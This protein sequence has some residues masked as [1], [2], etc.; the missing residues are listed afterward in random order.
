[1]WGVTK[2]GTSPAT[3]GR[4]RGERWFL[5]TMVVSVTRSKTDTKNRCQGTDF[6]GQRTGTGSV[7]SLTSHI[8]SGLWSVWLCMVFTICTVYLFIKL[9]GFAVWLE[10]IQLSSELKMFTF[11]LSVSGRWVTNTKIKKNHIIPS[12]DLLKHFKS[13]PSWGFTATGYDIEPWAE[14]PFSPLSSLCQ[15]FYHG[16]ET[17]CW[18]SQAA[19][20]HFCC[21]PHCLDPLAPVLLSV[22]FGGF[23]GRDWAL[24]SAELN[25]LCHRPQ[26]ES[27][28]S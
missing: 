1:M 8:V 20:W 7:R 13:V 22:P 23:C 24:C 27:V 26:L 5:E 17:W 21:S 28:V 4:G 2:P 11:V 19:Q 16:K 14:T 3:T 12:W 10:R 25:K 18:D 15:I 6:I 9:N